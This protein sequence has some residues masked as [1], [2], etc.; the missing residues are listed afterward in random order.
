MMHNVE[1]YFTYQAR[2]WKTEYHDQL[3]KSY[4]DNPLIETLPPAY[5]RDQ[6]YRLLQYDPGCD[7]SYRQWPTHLRLH[8]FLEA[9]RFFQPLNIH[10]ELEQRLSRMIRAGYVGRNPLDLGFWAE[11]ERRLHLVEEN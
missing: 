3:L 9:A 10:I 5:N 8:L 6:V 7:E 4:R 11:T 1:S 2:F